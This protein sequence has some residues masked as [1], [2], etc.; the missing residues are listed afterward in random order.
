MQRWVTVAKR[1]GVLMQL[2]PF[3]S[4]SSLFFLV[5]LLTKQ[6]RSWLGA[7]KATQ[8]QAT[9]PIRTSKRP[10]SWLCG[11]VWCKCVEGVVRANGVGREMTPP[12]AA[13]FL[14]WK[15]VMA[16]FWFCEAKAQG[17]FY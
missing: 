15:F 16:W 13:S 10:R 11:A 3:C 7:T 14:P 6:G 17:N 12:A 4:P 1:L 9:G 2:L 5:R 8:N